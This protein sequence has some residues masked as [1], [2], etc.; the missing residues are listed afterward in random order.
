MGWND[1]TKKFH[2]PLRANDDMPMHIK[3][4]AQWPEKGGVWN[5]HIQDREGGLWPI[6]FFNNDRWLLNVEKGEALS[7]SD[8]RIPR[9]E[10]GLGWWNINDPQHPDH[11]R[12]ELVSSREPKPEV[13][14]DDEEEEFHAAN[15]PPRN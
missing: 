9:G 15:P 4:D 13:S 5:Y 11:K 2:V 12:L 1:L 3:G 6:A 8:W 7:R 10:Y 14:S